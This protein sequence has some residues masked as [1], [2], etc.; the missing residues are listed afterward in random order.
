MVALKAATPE[1]AASVHT[2]VATEVAKKK[3]ATYCD[4]INGNCGGGDSQR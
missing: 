1:T 3:V 2:T 4:G